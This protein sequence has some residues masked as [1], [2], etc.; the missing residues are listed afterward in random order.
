MIRRRRI[1]R[2]PRRTRMT[3]ESIEMCATCSEK[4]M[5]WHEVDLLIWIICE[6]CSKCN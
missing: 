5:N 4:K 1:I 2:R 6:F 3:A